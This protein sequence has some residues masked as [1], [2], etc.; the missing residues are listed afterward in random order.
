[1]ILRSRISWAIF[2]GLISRQEAS[3]TIKRYPRS[4]CSWSWI[5][6]H[7]ECWDRG[8]ENG[9]E[10]IIITEVPYQMNKKIRR[11]VAELVLDKIIVGIGEIRDESNKE[12]I[13][14]VFELKRDAFPKKSRTSS[15]NLLHFK[16]VFHL[17]WLLWRGVDSSLV[18]STWK[19]CS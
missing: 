19:K 11:K 2:M 15:I 1:M 13:W 12:G 7:E 4:L 10:A 3:S 6:R 8:D 9:K 5:C 17:T 18:S 16:Q 14:V